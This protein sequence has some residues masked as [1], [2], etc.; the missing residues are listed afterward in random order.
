MVKINI[1]LFSE[2]GVDV[3]NYFRENSEQRIFACYAISTVTRYLSQGGFCFTRRLLV[4][5]SVC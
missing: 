1:L 5:L 2:H 4:C 3:V